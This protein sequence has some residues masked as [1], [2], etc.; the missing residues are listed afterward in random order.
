[1]L[2][3]EIKEINNDNFLSAGEMPLPELYFM[4]ALLFFLSGCFWVFLLKK[5]KYVSNSYF[6]INNDIKF[7]SLHVV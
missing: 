3:M 1:M 6:N 5:S 4:M 7:Y 2:Q